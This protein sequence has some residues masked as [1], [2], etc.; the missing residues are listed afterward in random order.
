ML[1]VTRNKMQLIHP[2]CKDIVSHKEDFKQH[3]IV[4]T[5][6]DSFLVEIDHGVIIK[7]Q[8]MRAT[9]EEAD[10]ILV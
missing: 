7:R 3:K 9:R 5:G 1:T 4:L 10:T 8:D 6:S 2:I